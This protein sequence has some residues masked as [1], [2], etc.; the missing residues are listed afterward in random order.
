MGCYDI[1]LFNCRK[2]GAEMDAQSKSGP[3]MLDEFDMDSVPEDVAVDAN[4][5]APFV[6]DCGESHTF[7]VNPS[8]EIERLEFE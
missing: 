3:C 8:T 2:C 1:I 7:V 4:R 6:C 5:H